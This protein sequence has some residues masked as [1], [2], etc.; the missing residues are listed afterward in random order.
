MQ[1][2]PT[3][4]LRSPWRD[5]NCVSVF[6]AQLGQPTAATG[7]ADTGWSTQPRMVPTCQI[8]NHTHTNKI[9][10]HIHNQ[11][12]A[13]SH[14]ILWLFHYIACSHLRAWMIRLCFSIVRVAAQVLVIEQILV[15]HLR[16]S[17]ADGG[18]TGAGGDHGIAHSKNWLRFSDVFI[19]LNVSPS[20]RNL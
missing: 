3:S 9:L 8:Q 19:S 17:H 15:D 11:V 6:H 12:L 7:P 4:N 2:P 10:I 14:V 16:S 1:G 18:Y 5:F 13:I 20:E